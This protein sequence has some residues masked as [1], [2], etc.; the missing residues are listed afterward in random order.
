MSV[1]TL[2]SR[3]Q[4][5]RPA[6]RQQVTAR[7]TL[8][9]LALVVFAFVQHCGKCFM[10]QIVGKM[11]QQD[12]DP[13]G[14]ISVG[15][16]RAAIE[17]ESLD[18]TL[19]AFDTQERK[20]L[21]TE[22]TELWQDAQ[23]EVRAE[24]PDIDKDPFFNTNLPGLFRRYLLANELSP[25]QAI[26]AL[27][28]TAQW[29]KEWDV[30]SYYAPG[31]AMDLFAESSNPGA[32]MYAADSLSVDKQGRP[33]VAGRLRF[34][35]PE[36]MHPWRHLRAGVLVFELMATKIAQ[37]G[38]GPASYIL[39]VGP[40]GNVL[41]KVSGTAG[42]DR[43]YE[44]SVNPYYKAGAGTADAPSQKMVEELG[45]LDNGFLVLKAAIKILNKHY[46][47]VIGRV[48]Y[49]NSDMIFWGA[50]KVFSRWISDSGSIEFQFLG[51]AGWR[52]EP[53]CT[54]LDSYEKEQL[55]PEWC[56]TGTPL[57]GDAF[58]QRALDYYEASARE[59]VEAE[60]AARDSQQVREPVAA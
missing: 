8:V 53:I 14:T 50:F 22:V 20:Q 26:A 16:A 47:G 46:P 60:Q 17:G 23:E 35:N 44:E 9:L 1:P 3:A 25:T 59:Q 6:R 12:K 21:V 7:S 4:G 13:D 56:G 33:Y 24:Y 41:G 55:P 42:L 18:P 52:E 2:V 48:Y 43:K 51:E 15:Q 39:D 54:L 19:K 49:L 36:N 58:L 45:S 10:G 40:I 28:E 11:R 27:R 34:A 38:R 30:L 37:L 29:R 32:E 5:R 57:D 31:A